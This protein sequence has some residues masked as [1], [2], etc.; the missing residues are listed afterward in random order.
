MQP[1]FGWTPQSVELQ[2]TIAGTGYTGATQSMTIAPATAPAWSITGGTQVT[3]LSGN[4][5]IAFGPSG[6]MSTGNITLVDSADGLT[7]T[8]TTIAYGGLSG[9][10]TNSSGQ[11]VATVTVDANGD[12]TI[13]YTSGA[14]AQIRDWVILSS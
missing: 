7:I 8:L 6:M 13:N 5:T 3:T 12:G 9:N 14:T 11:T 10:V 1:N 4:A 2:L